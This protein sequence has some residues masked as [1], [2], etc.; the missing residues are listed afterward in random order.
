MALKPA[1]AASA[2]GR[3]TA[4]NTAAWSVPAS[5]TWSNRKLWTASDDTSPGLGARRAVISPV[6]G[7]TWT[8]TPVL[9]EDRTRTYTPIVSVLSQDMATDGTHAQTPQKSE[10]IRGE[11]LL[12][13]ESEK[14]KRAPAAAT[15]ELDRAATFFSSI[16]AST[17]NPSTG[18]AHVHSLYGLP[19]VVGSLSEAAPIYEHND[20][21]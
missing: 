12:E 2:I 21:I 7:E 16:F 11:H 6:V 3:P 20:N 8:H 9:S 13:R 19:N 4:S 10:K 1:S 18:I 15:Q 17:C 14:G 5:P